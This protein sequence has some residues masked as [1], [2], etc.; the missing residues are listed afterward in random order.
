MCVC[1]QVLAQGVVPPWLSS[2]PAREHTSP[3]ARLACNIWM[4]LH[5]DVDWLLKV[6]LVC[7][8]PFPHPVWT[9]A[10]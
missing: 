7:C 8:L 5:K 9:L 2:P 3:L 6:R 1:L 10:S 4:H